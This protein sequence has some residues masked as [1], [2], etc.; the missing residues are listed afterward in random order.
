MPK[1]K[2]QSTNLDRRLIGKAELCRRL[3]VTYPTVWRWINAGY[4]PPGMQLG[5]GEPGSAKLAWWDDVV[6]AWIAAR[7]VQQ[8]KGDKR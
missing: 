1:R 2:S 4:F 3:G 8:V 6:D 5:A 7:P